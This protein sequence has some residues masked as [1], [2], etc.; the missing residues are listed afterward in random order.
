M[1]QVHPFFKSTNSFYEHQEHSHF[2]PYSAMFHYGFKN[3]PWLI[4]QRITQHWF[5]CQQRFWQQYLEWA[6]WQQQT[7]H[8]SM[9]D[10]SRWMMHCMQLSN[11]PEKLHRYLRLNWQKPYLSMASQAV[12]SNRMLMHLMIDNW[13]TWQKI[14]SQNDNST[15]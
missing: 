9:M 7:M 6:T 5:E 13:C 15:H 11:Q 2:E 14:M 8:Q 12:A 10:S 1:A 3:A 4:S